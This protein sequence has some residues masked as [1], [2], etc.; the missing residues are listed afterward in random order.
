MQP[1]RVVIPLPGP[2]GF[3]PPCRRRRKISG[4]RVAQI[5]GAVSNDFLPR[6]CPHPF[7]KVVRLRVF[8]AVNPV[9]SDDPLFQHAD[10][11]GFEARKRFVRPVHQNGADHQHFFVRILCLHPQMNGCRTVDGRFPSDLRT[12]KQMI[13]SGSPVKCFLQQ[14]G[15]VPMGAPGENGILFPVFRNDLQFMP[16]VPLFRGDKLTVRIVLNRHIGHPCR[17]VV[18]AKQRMGKPQIQP[19]R[20]SMLP[21]QDVGFCLL[22]GRC[23]V[24]VLMQQASDFAPRMQQGT[25][26][27]IKL[28]RL[29]RFVVH[30]LH[31]QGRSVK[32][33]RR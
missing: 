8:T 21:D 24:S 3:V 26:H 18:N 9:L 4:F 33:R 13:L 14:N 6:L 5:H 12:P 15:V 32:T 22:I 27:Q 11:S 16:G 17:F 30:S 29:H 10:G 25:A 2:D 23:H 7:H 19:F 20:K 31:D 1:K 28:F